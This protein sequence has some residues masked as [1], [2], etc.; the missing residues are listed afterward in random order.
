MEKA[1]N[2]P[3]DDF[4]E[5][6]FVDQV[7]PLLEQA[8]NTLNETNGAIKGADPKGE[9]SK[10]AQRRASDHKASEEEQRLAEGLTK[11]RLWDS[12]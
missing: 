5:D 9:L 1:S 4:D 12:T 6:K 10:N 8:T 3:K 2:T 7:K 11:V